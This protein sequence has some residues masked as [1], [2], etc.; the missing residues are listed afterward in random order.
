MDRRIEIEIEPHEAAERLDRVLARRLPELSRTR[1]KSLIEAG[2]VADADGPVLKPNARASGVV[3]IDLPPPEAAEPRPEAIPLAVVF[4]DADLVV[5][6]K[7]A[8]LV[9]HPAPGNWTGT[10]VNA[11]LAHCGAELSGVGGV[12][13]PG[14]VHRLDKDTSGLLVVAKSDAAHRGLADQFADHGRSGPLEREYLAF[15]WGAPRE[16]R[17][18]VEG[19]IGRDPRNREKMAIT[20]AGKPAVTHVERRAVY[21]GGE[22]SLLACR[23]ETGRTHQIR[24]HLAG[25]GHPILGDDLY[26]AGFRTKAQ[27]LPQEAARTVAGLGRQALHAHVLGFAHPTTGRSLRFRSEL[28]PE[29]ARLQDTLTRLA[30]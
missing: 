5:V 26:G 14:I 15:A 13:R 29:L 30:P 1:L 27:K 16:A 20:P 7:P 10:L 2:L 28:P 24:V 21:A 11:L 6:D 22:A 18:S 3:V 25:R 12:A 17:F 23:L 9:V 8:G 4:E 19:P